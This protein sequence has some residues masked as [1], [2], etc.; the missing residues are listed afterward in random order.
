MHSI[1]PALVRSA[2]SLTRSR[3]RRFLLAP[4]L[5]ALAVWGGLLWWMYTPWVT[6]AMQHPP[7]RWI[8]AR[9][10][11]WP[12]MLLGNLAVWMLVFA[13]AYLAALLVSAFC[14][15]PWILNEVAA[16]E[17]PELARMGKN[18]W[19]ASTGNSLFAIVGFSA[20]WV[21]TLPLWLIPGAGLILP[22]LLVAWL[23]RQMLAHD[24][25]AEFAAPEEWR[26]LRKQCARPMFVLGLMLAMLAHVPL[27]GLL[28]PAF[29]S[30][31]YTHYGLDALSRLR[32]D[33]TVIC[34][35]SATIVE[36]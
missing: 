28:I 25:F 6:W 24:T 1:L 27:L 29:S 18:R 9:G 17:Y 10:G 20:G 11:A 26:I 32:G 33:N 8:V 31:A 7:L 15:Y 22:L 2:L 19:A 4:F 21:V 34:Q 3:L 14:L 23:N 35:A 12:A 36:E 16:R 30:L 13:L 5:V